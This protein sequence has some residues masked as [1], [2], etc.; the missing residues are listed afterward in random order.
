M[1]PALESPPAARSDAR[2]VVTIVFADLA[3]STALHDA[4]DAEA[5]RSFMEGY[6]R[7]MAR[8]SPCT[9]EPSSSFSVTV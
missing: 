5:V 8:R 3:G 6:Y 9:A 7:A 1:R 4:L 2:K